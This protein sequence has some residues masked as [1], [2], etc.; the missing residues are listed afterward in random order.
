LTFV[1]R[2]YDDVAQNNCHQGIAR[3]ENQRLRRKLAECADGK[4]GQCST[5][6]STFNCGC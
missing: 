6:N 4:Q 2:M 1:N 3:G 5:D